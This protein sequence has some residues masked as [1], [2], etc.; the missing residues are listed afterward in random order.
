MKTFHRLWLVGAVA[1]LG[2]TLSV[3]PVAA[4]TGGDPDDGAHKNVG[5]LYVADYE[6]FLFCSASLLAPGEVLTAAHCPMVLEAMGIGPE[7]VVVSF[8][9]LVSFDGIQ[10][11]TA[12]PIAVT[13]W[14]V[15]PGFFYGGGNGIL[16]GDVAVLHLAHDYTDSSPIQLPTVGFLDGQAARGGLVGQEFVNVGYGVNS[17]DR[18]W[19]NL[20]AVSTWNG[21]R[22]FDFADFRA[23]TP[24][25][26][27][28][29]GGGCAG[30]SGGPVF[31]GDSNLQV[32]VSSTGSLNC[33]PSWGNSRL[34]TEAVLDWLEQYR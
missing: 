32:A 27:V 19:T 13:G 21:E 3:S 7:Q 17:V 4:I 11:S 25:Q 9:E 22:W 14:D 16:A 15:Y 6:G 31:F 24:A 23:L 18:A 26:L 33:G 8:D 20:R 1:A 2:L 29:S 28:V 34:D 5:I 12:N 10:V 30:D